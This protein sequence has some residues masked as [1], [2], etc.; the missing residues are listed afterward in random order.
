MSY[1]CENRLVKL[2]NKDLLSLM[3]KDGG[4]SG[5]PSSSE[6]A[7]LKEHIV[8]SQED[9]GVDSS[10][11]DQG[12]SNAQA[13]LADTLQSAGAEG[14]TAKDLLSAGVSE[15]YATEALA[16]E[17]REQLPL[18]PEVLNIQ[19]QTRKGIF[20][21]VGEFLSGAWSKLKGFFGR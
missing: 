10:V 21:S 17:V 7:D 6:V 14:L 16:D 20:A 3:K 11:E 8:V 5:V 15:G 13:E 12:E 4:V 19:S 18:S 9:G 2:L 1:F